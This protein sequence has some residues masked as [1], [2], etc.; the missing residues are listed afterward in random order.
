MENI[1][2]HNPE[3]SKERFWKKVAITAN[4]N[5]CWEWKGAYRPRTGYGSITVNKKSISTHRYSY[6]INKGEIPKGLCVLHSCD[7]PICVNPNHLTVGTH[8]ENSSDMV[9]KGR[10][11]K[12]IRSGRYTKP[13]KNVKGIKNH[14][15]KLT[16]A[17]VL[18]IRASKH[19]T[20]ELALLYG[21][22]VDTILDIRSR[23][24]WKH[25]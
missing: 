1:V 8:A 18:E 11:A 3:K 6:S 23:H 7:N 2:K 24:T 17:Q 9:R 16:E 19:K 21:V 15:H 10:Q 13:E 5:K 14:L 25:I 12:G 20:K 4:P 22:R